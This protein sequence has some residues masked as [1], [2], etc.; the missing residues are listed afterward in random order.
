MISPQDFDRLSAYLDNQLSPAEKARFESRLEREPDLRAAL[1]DL[2][3]TVRALRSLPVLKPP[4]NFTLSPA[5]AR[6]IAPPRRVFPALRLATAL[7]ALAF[8]V[9]AVGDFAANLASPS[10]RAASAPEVPVTV[11]VAEKSAAATAAPASTA[12][13]QGIVE[14]EEVLAESV[15]IAAGAADATTGAET[16]TPQAAA[17]LPL[18]SPTG[19]PES[20]TGVASDASSPAAATPGLDET[21]TTRTRSAVTATAT[22]A[23]VLAAPLFTNAATPTAAAALLA[24]TTGGLPPLRYVEIGL[25]L[26]ALLLAAAAWLLRGR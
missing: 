21:D 3:A 18:P 24:E 9:V 22:P 6:A 12:A 14:T 7:T 26:L 5:Q 2:R 25:A 4:R 20:G 19:T 13:A 16:E 15:G 1:D 11:V 10:P 17:A 23:A 8:V